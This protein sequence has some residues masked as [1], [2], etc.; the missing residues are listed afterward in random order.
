MKAGAKHPQ[1]AA[2]KMPSASDNPYT[3]GMQEARIAYGSRRG[4]R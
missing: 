2:G 3:R 4:G 1:E